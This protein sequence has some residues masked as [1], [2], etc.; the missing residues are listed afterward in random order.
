[1]RGHNSCSWNDCNLQSMKKLFIINSC[2]RAI[3]SS[4][5]DDLSHLQALCDTLISANH[6]KVIDHGLCKSCILQK[7]FLAKNCLTWKWNDVAASAVEFNIDKRNLLQESTI[8]GE[9][10]EGTL[11][12]LGIW[13]PS[14]PSTHSGN[15]IIWCWKGTRIL[16]CPI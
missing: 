3:V 4:R 9:T 6:K 1:M 14:T 10:F 2:I 7:N 12:N 11:T 8:D 16:L 13:G 5:Y 15:D